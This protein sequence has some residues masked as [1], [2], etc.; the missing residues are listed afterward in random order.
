MKNSSSA[1]FYVTGGTL[2]LDQPSYV[3]R[4]ADADLYD[5]LTRGEFCY[6]LTSRQ[7]GKSS[8]MVRAAARLRAEGVAVALLDL[9]AVGQNL[10]AEQWYDGLL[11]RLGEELGLEDELEAFWRDHD[12]LSPLLRWMQAV[13]EV[14]LAR[15]P[16][17]VVIFIDE[18]DYVRSLPFSTDEFF[19]AIRACYNRRSDDAAL[20]RLT[21][22]LLGVATPSDL[23]RDTRTTPFN[24][25]RRVELHDFT[26]TE[27]AP[28]A[29][30]LGR[31]KRTAVRL[32]GRV[33]HWSGGHPYLTQ[34]LCRAVA[35]APAVRDS[36]GVDRLCADL[37]LSSRARERDDNLLFVRERLLRSAEVPRADLLDLYARLLRTGRLR[38]DETSP[39]IGVLRLSGITRARGGHLRVRNRI[40]RRVFD[41]AWIRANMPDA[42]RRRQRSAFWRGLS[43]ATASSLLVLAIILVLGLYAK[44]SAQNEAIALRKA[45]ESA[46]NEAIALRKVGEADRKANESYKKE[47]KENERRLRF[48]RSAAVLAMDRALTL[49]DKGEVTD[50]ML[51]MARSLELAPENPADLQHIARTELAAWRHHMS[52][53]RAMVEHRDGVN[54]VAF[55]PDGTRVLTG[56]EDSTA[57]LWDVATGQPLG[58]PQTHKSPVTVVAFSPD[59][60]L[61]LTGSEDSTARLWDTATGQPL[62]EPLI[63][64]G[65]VWSATFSPD[66]SRVLT[67]SDDATARLWDVATGRPLGNPLTH[68]GT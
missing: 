20:D 3:T 9:T 19:A 2:G 29:D 41:H 47:L 56:C 64:G 18:V 46:Q 44:E 39:L 27:A 36:S 51:W 50:G 31:D 28:L 65:A 61:M 34:R 38:D 25:G 17:R 55:S 58:K 23:I 63:H 62:G 53:L 4:R 30:G 45:K 5:G 13:S 11:M 1:D 24:I 52:P 22:C 68:K 54:A 8:L 32:L 48:Q 57:Q 14:V 43:L 16:G 10:T 21:F 12:R 59:G 66:G 6:V 7:M 35:E 33:L 42:E 37:F 49:C 67:G 60:M 15:C 26:P 40:Y